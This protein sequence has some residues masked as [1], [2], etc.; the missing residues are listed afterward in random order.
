[1]LRVGLT[2]GIGSGKS[3]VARIFSVLGIP[4]FD[5]DSAS[6]NLM[7]EDEDLKN[8]I[9]KH[10]GNQ[11]YMGK[12]LSTKYLAEQ[13]FG[14]DKK[15]ALLNSIVHPATIQAAEKWMRNQKS[16]YVIKEAALIFESGSD[17]MLDKVIGISSPL[18]LRIERTMKRNN[19]TQQQ[20]QQRINQQ[21]DEDEKMRLCDYVIINDE[22]Q[23][24]IP[25]VLQLHEKLLEMAKETER[26]N[27]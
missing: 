10:F 3:T 4:V 8:E 22:R 25:Q 13:V 23:M 6:K 26:T 20:V 27:Q 1:M 15:T 11:S 7:S 18:A 5:A 19:L 16:P 2:G 12:K 21:M 9:I 24:L 14:D 17:R